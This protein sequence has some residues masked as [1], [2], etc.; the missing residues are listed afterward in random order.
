MEQEKVQGVESKVSGGWTYL[1]LSV[2]VTGVKTLVPESDS[3]GFRFIP[4]FRADDGSMI[5]A[6]WS[7]GFVLPGINGKNVVVFCHFYGITEDDF[8]TEVTATTEVIKKER[9]G[10]VYTLVNHRKTGGPVKFGINFKSKGNGIQVYG[11]TARVNFH[12]L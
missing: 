5:E 8:G 3:K 6:H 7:K 1:L 2:P 12:T 10:E 9:G 11:S 4:A